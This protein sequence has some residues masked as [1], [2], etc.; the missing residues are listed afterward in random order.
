M[1]FEEKLKQLETLLAK[2]EDTHTG[3][4]EAMQ[5]FE[6]AMALKKELSEALSAYE[7][8]LEELVIENARSKHV[9]FAMLGEEQET[10]EVEDEEF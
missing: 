3:L 8:K 4:D 6:Q 2:I 10:A 1:K 9:P 5:L 7:G